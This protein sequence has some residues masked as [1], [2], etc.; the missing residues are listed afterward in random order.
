MKHNLTSPIDVN[1]DVDIPG[2]DLE[3]LVEKVG[4]VSMLVI[5]T[6]MATDTVRHIL[7]SLFK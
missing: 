1:L 7:K 4:E 3:N 6:Y 5:A 2:Q